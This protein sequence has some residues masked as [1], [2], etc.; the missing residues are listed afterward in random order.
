MRG[1]DDPPRRPWVP[2]HSN[3]RGS[4]DSVRGLVR[5]CVFFYTPI[6]LPQRVN[7]IVP[8]LSVVRGPLF[9]GDELVV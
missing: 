4:P 7:D 3:V 8:D 5:K 9:E 2:C 6:Q 1:D